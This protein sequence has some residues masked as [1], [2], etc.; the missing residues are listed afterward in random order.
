MPA[1]AEYAQEY[2]EIPNFH[3]K[4]T[5]QNNGSLKIK[6]SI[7]ADFA[8]E[9]HRGIARIIPY[10]FSS[11]TP[12]KT[13][14]TPITFNSATDQNGKSWNNETYNS[15]GFFNLEMRTDGNIANNLINIFNIDYTIENVINEF[16]D[17]DEL[18]FNIN[19]TDWP[20]TIDNLTA[21]VTLPEP[22]EPT[23]V[24]IKC[25]TGSLYQ[26][27]SDCKW[28]FEDNLHIN[29][30]TT[31]KLNAYENMTVVIGMPSRVITIP[32]TPA[33]DL[34]I[35]LLLTL[36]TFNAPIVAIIMLTLWYKKGRDEKTFKDTV[37]PHYHAP[38]N[39]KP[40]EV[41]TLIDEKISARD[42]TATIIDYAIK[43]NIKI[44]ETK[45]DNILFDSKDY[46]LE[47]IEPYKTDK[48][49]EKILLE[50]IFPFNVAGESTT[51]SSLQN[52]FYKKIPIIKRSVTKQLITDG[53]FPHN[54]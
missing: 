19:G 31:K 32:A 36:L 46:K 40:T 26:E 25:I 23:E 45:K 14:K 49:Y 6:E 12:L 39:L 53:Y 35:Q 44:H 33:K 8:N 27:N 51:L 38:N 52:K 17:H 48:E 15:N 37:I 10:K 29:F 30:E 4:I 7:S 43:G 24:Q 21:T 34:L 2:W 9:A 11:T 20:V 41:G 13:R 28:T 5:I 18:Y 22:L 50:S 47:L 1:F 42:M 3:S 16:K 54:P